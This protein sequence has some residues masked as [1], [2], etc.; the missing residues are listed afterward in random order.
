PQTP[1]ASDSGSQ[2]Q[3]TDAP[4]A[5][6]ST[7]SST[8]DNT[9]STH[10][11]VSNCPTEDW[12][13]D[14][15][16]LIDAFG[17]AAQSNA[18]PSN[19][20]SA[21]PNT[22]AP[23]PDQ[24]AAKPGAPTAKSAERSSRPRSAAPLPPSAV[25]G[26]VV[27]SPG[28]QGSQVKITVHDVTTEEQL[29]RVPVNKSVLVDLSV[30]AREVRLAKP[31]FADVNFINP[32]QLII[33][34]KSFGSTQ[35]ILTFGEKDQRV[36]DV[37]VDLEMERLLAGIRTAV[38]RSKV[39]AH[40]LMDSIVLSGEIPDAE[41]ADRIIQIANVFS[42]K[43]LNHMHIAGTQQVL[44][45]CTV[46]EISKS[47]TRQLGFNGWMGGE[48]LRDMFF[49]NNLNQ[50][51]PSDIGAVAGASMVGRVPFA[52]GADGIPITG[53]STLSVGFPRV[54]MQMFIQAL[55]ENGVLRVLAEPN[56]VAINGQSASFLAGGE[57]P[58]PISTSDTV[59]IKFKEFGVRLNFTPAVL[60]ESRIRLK[61]APEVSEP[62]FAN[63]VTFGGIS[64]PGFATRRVETTIELANGETL[65]I[66]GLLNER[67]RAIGVSADQVTSV[68]GAQF[69]QPNDFEL[70]LL[71]KQEGETKDGAPALQPRINHHWPVKPGDAS[72][73]PK[74][75]GPVGP[76]SGDEGR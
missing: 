11:G 28:A 76:T 27:T 43:V 9:P 47:V 67:I 38:P 46:A 14:L 20:T 21:S 6:E 4:P 40:A 53:N 7:Q 35:L 31:E 61:V 59:D 30:P 57:I 54:Q 58:I 71:N 42:T 39:K 55:R 65:A 34:G 25:K 50:I 70:Y 32:T 3:S 49:V 52:T 10:D 62:D 72:A 16:Q 48:N 18:E 19:P 17:N 37:A 66:G 74:V 26:Q 13:T 64:V 45:R 8:Q 15:S 1:P 41:S 51:N 24:N 56:V 12:T 63:S 2:R 68:P 5:P 22:N 60:S 73:A 69:V 36:F 33:T 23:K 75:R 44:L 29:I